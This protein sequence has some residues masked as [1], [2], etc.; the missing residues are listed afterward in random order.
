LV[1][2][3][4]ERRNLAQDPAMSGMLT[5]MRGRLDA[6]MLRTNDP[7]L[8]GPVKAPAGAQV[9]DPNGTSPQEPT[10]PA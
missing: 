8:K 1:F 5:E 9:N 2:D 4:Q 10:R 7:L 3:P 6:W